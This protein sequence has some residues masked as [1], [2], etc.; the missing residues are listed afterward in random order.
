MHEVIA[1]NVQQLSSQAEQAEKQNQWAEAVQLYSQAL[2]ESPDNQTAKERLGWCLSRAKEYE[3]ATAIF[4]ELAQHQP[5]IAKWPYM[6]GY[7]YHEQ[8]HWREAIDWY[9]KSLTLNP[10][11]IVVLYRKGYAH[12]KLGQVGEALQAFERCRKLWRALP[13]G[14]LKDKD[15][16]NCAKAAYHQAEVLIENWR[17]VEGTFEAAIQL[18]GE[19]ISLDPA[20]YNAH[21]LLGKAYLESGQ[22]EKAIEAFQESDH[23]QPNQ[24]YVLDRWGQALAQLKRHDE[25]EKI[26][27]RIPPPQRKDY[28]LRNLGEIQL[29][30]GDHQRA[31]ATLKQA[32]QKNGRNHNAHYYLGLCYRAASEWAL[33]VHELREAIRLRQKHYKLPF[34]DAQKALDEIL[35]QHPEAASMLREG[36][37]QRGKVIKYFEEKGYGFIQAGSG[38]LFFHVKDC[39]RGERI[40]VGMVFEYDEG[41]GDKGPKAIKLRRIG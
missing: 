23:L 14:L 12:F 31:I 17:I 13:E 15:K 27:Q 36:Q 29:Q 9:S 5:E 38:Q 24:E 40:E 20:N 4:Q 11:Y 1:V 10:D 26:Y 7:Q 16:K 41:M 30:K 19:V 35:S 37:R 28:T 34:P 2:Q 3:K 39:P 22:P 8:Q 33:A 25:A 18:L 32:I 6:I 21:Y